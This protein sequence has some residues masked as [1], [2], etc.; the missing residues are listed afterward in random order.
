MV[1][2]EQL[3]AWFVADVL[4]LEAQLLSYL[5]KHWRV[6]TERRDLLHD[7]YERALTGASKGLPQNSRAYL[8]TITRNLLIT[9]AR[10]G[11]IVSFEL[12]ADLDGLPVDDDLLTPERHASARQE[13]RR[14]LEGMERL[15]PRCR[16]VVRLRKVE[17][18]STKEVAARMNVGIDAVERQMT[19]GMRALAD[20]MLGGEGRIER[21]PRQSAKIVSK[22]PDHA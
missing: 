8:F 9:R 11:R 22:R 20:F 4:P 17:G 7:V 10:R 6:H 1:S 16:E 3:H 21:K 15:P 14:A 18:L 13:L 19:L 2:D 12:V 5:Q